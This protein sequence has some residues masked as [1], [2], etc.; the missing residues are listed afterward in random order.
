MR[1]SAGPDPY[2]KQQQKQKWTEMKHHK[3][4]WNVAKAANEKH[5]KTT[6]SGAVSETDAIVSI[7]IRQ[8]K[9]VQKYNVTSQESLNR[10]INPE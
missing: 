8:K 10:I 4:C 7:K 9:K 6:N 5:E 1:T 2:K 3:A